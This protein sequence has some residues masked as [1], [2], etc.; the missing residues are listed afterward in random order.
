MYG[1]SV[2][3]ITESE[4]ISNNQARLEDTINNQRNMWV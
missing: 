1:L 2:Y 3:Q 4:I